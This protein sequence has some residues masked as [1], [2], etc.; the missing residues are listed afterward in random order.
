ML[1]D[2]R[3]LGKFRMEGAGDVTRVAKRCGKIDKVGEGLLDG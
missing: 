2:G 3:V 1:I